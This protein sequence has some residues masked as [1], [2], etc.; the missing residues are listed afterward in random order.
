M[1]QLNEAQVDLIYERLQREGLKNRKLEQ[2]LFDHFCCHIEEQMEAGEEFE[3]A[4]RNAVAAI[5]PQGA[6]EIEFE[7]F[8]I[9]NFNKQVSMKKLIFLA[10]FTAAFLISTG[11]MFRTLHWPAAQMVLF[12]GFAVLLLTVVLHALH[13]VRFLRRQSGGFWLRTITGLASLGLI[14]LGIMFKT[15]HFPGANIMYGLGTIILNF[16]FLPMFF[17]RIYKHGFVKTAANET[18]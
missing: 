3:R 12:S 9:M 13:A 7:L 6:K 15:L 14:A 17:Y 5:S 16:L 4:Y 18:V 10:G 1:F 11:M 2:D 8:F